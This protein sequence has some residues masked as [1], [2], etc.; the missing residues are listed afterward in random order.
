MAIVVKRASTP[1]CSSSCVLVGYLEN[2]I[3]DRQLMAHCS[4]RLDILFFIG[5]DIDEELPWHSTI[6]RTR[7]LFPES[8]FEEVFTNVLSLCVEKGMVSGHTQSID[9]APV[10]SNASMDTLELKGTRRRFRGTFTQ[11]TCAQH[12]GQRSSPPQEQRR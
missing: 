9:S 2:L 11:S 8:V 7:Q 5:Y 3:S 10:K 12:N 4:M 6:S 1:W